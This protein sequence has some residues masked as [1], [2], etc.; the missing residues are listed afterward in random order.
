MLSAHAVVLSAEWGADVIGKLWQ[1]VQD[2]FSTRPVTVDAQGTIDVVTM[3]GTNVPEKVSNYVSNLNLPVPANTRFDPYT[4]STYNP[5]K[6]D[7]DKY[8][9]HNALGTD[10]WRGGWTWVG[11]RGPELLNLPAGSRILSN[12]ESVRLADAVDRA[13]SEPA[14]AASAQRSVS[15][16]LPPAAGATRTA[17]DNRQWAQ[18]DQRS[19][20]GGSTV[21]GST[22]VGSTVGGSTVVGD[23]T[24]SLFSSLASSSLSAISMA[25]DT[26]S[27]SALV[28]PDNSIATESS[29]AN[30]FVAGGNDVRT[31]AA[32][33]LPAQSERRALQVIA[34]I[35]GD[36]VERQSRAQQQQSRAQAQQ[37]SRA[38]AQQQSRAQQQA[39]NAVFRF[40]PDFTRSGETASFPLGERAAAIRLATT[41]APER[42]DAVADREEQASPLARLGGWW[43]RMRNSRQAA[44]D[45]ANAANSP[46]AAVGGHAAAI[47]VAVYALP[48]LGAVTSEDAPRG[49]ITPPVDVFANV[50][51]RADGGPA[52]GWAVVG[53]RGPELAF[54]AG[55]GA[56]ILSNERSAALLATAGVRGV[57]GFA[58]G[59]TP[60]DPAKAFFNALKA[61]AKMFG[62]WVPQKPA[63]RQY[64]P[65]TRD[66]AW[67]NWQSFQRKGVEAMQGAAQQTGDAFEKVAEQTNDAFKSALQNVPGLFGASPVT[68]DQMQM[69]ELG[70]PQNFADNYLR[71]LS[72]EVLNG[73]DW[74]GVDIGDAARRAGIDPNLPADVILQLFK[75][76]WNNSSLFANP[77]NLDLIDQSAV[78]AAIE[79]Q[80]QELAGKANIMGLFGIDDKNLQGQ[81]DALGAGL[82]SVFGQAAQTDAMKAAG[83]QAFA[84]VGAGFSDP[85]TATA[86][87]GGMANAVIVA[88]GV[89]EN[90][91]ALGDAGRAGAAAYYDGWKSAMSELPPVPPTGTTTLVGTA[92]GTATLTIPLPAGS[93]QTPVGHNALGTTN[94][95]GGWTMVGEYGTELVDLPQ[96]ARVHDAGETRRWRAGRT[97]GRADGARNERPVVV[98]QTFVV[99]DKLMAEQAARRA[100]Q[101]IRRGS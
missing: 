41:S 27:Y 6:R 7:K 76:S 23:T 94:W 50:Q 37:Q 71:R 85:N 97:Q 81:A 69:A 52:R 82:A 56:H 89:P 62:L 54:F 73:V 74:A 64:G 101:L 8:P 32:A 58:E 61:G 10:N 88:T 14:G 22:V 70:V 44:I 93:T 2:F 35:Q 75:E 100:V 96:G 17:I 95:R 79:Q 12:P 45:G 66:E 48:R 29:E 4:E 16:F 68:A 31:G 53:E 67:G 26:V 28:A 80:Q 42:G 60:T 39:V 18:Y 46:V 9:G 57:P 20:V 86:A 38:Q 59:T 1:R 5:P 72:D 84:A 25:G 92:G 49:G 78:K 30:V 77:A 19:I 63:G 83:V 55:A 24:S 33:V 47:P 90:R 65:P 36:A 3:T 11:E 98:N 34:A 51:R 87:V 43:N 13:A 91:A 21:G 40:S 99:N 15:P